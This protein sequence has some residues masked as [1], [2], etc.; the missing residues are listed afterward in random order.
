MNVALGIYRTPTFHMISGLEGS[1]TYPFM[2]IIGDRWGTFEDIVDL[3]LYASMKCDKILFSLD[4]ILPNVKEGIYDSVTCKELDTLLNSR[5]ISLSKIEFYKNG[6]I[7]NTNDV[8][9]LYGYSH[10]LEF[11]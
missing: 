5:H 11:V 9:V 4:D 10:L 7:I 6:E 8:L 3:V 1:Y 2:E